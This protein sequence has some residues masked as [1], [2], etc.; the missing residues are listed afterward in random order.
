MAVLICADLHLDAW[1]REGRCPLAGVAQALGHLDALIVAGDLAG[2][3]VHRWSAALARLSRFLSPDRIWIVP[4]NHDYWGLRLGDDRTLAEIAAS[5]GVNLA[6]RRVVEVAG[7]RY[8]CCTLW[9]DWNLNGDARTAMVGAR[10]F[11]DFRAIHAPHDRNVRARPAD[12]LKLHRGDIEWLRREI[13]RPWGG[14][15]IVVTHHAPIRTAV[16]PYTVGAAAFASDLEHWM[17]GFDLDSWIYGHTHRIC[18]RMV[19]SSR[20]LNVSVG[21]PSEVSDCVAPELMLRG[22][23]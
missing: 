18:E 14:R 13:T 3:P 9:T 15:R 6:Q 20:I 16:D 19:G 7:D 12:T 4:G 17:S 8:Y 23:Q 5:V 22:L 11:P 2:Y 21:Y 1:A 10:D